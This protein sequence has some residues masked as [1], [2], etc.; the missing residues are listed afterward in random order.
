MSALETCLS[1]QNTN[2]TGKGLRSMLDA[3][4]YNLVFPPDEDVC[5]MDFTTAMTKLW[6]R[7]F[8]VI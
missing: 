3:G 5:D 8:L 1:P 4:V 2:M 6:S 7:Y